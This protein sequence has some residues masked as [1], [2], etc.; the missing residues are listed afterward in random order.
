M[1]DTTSS[2]QAA[3]SLPAKMLGAASAE[4]D[5]D[6]AEVP[7]SDV[8]KAEVTPAHVQ[9]IA[10]ADN[11]VPAVAHGDSERPMDPGLQDLGWS[12]DPKVPIPVLHGMMN[13]DVWTLVRR[14]NKQ[15]YHAKKLEEEPQGGIDMNIADKD[16]FTPDKLRSTLERIYMSVGLGG[17]AFFKH[18]ARVRSWKEYRRTSLFFVFY[19][20]GWV[21]DFLGPIMSAFIILLLASPQSRRILFPPAPLAAISAKTGVARVPKA[22]HLGSESLTGAAES[23]KGEAVENE[24]SNLVG[25]V[26]HMAVSAAIG[27]DQSAAQASQVGDVEGD[28]DDDVDDDDHEADSKKKSE[29][30]KMEDDLPDP[31]AIT[32]GSKAAHSKASDDKIEKKG[33]HSAEPVQSAVWGSAQPI[34][35]TLEDLVDTWE[36]FGNALSPTAPFA[37]HGPRLKIASI[38]APIFLLSLFTTPYMVYKG[39]T[40]GAGFGFF[41]QPLF[42]HLKFS[43]L[44]KFLDEKIPDWPRYLELRNSILKGVPTNAQL[45]IT[46]LRIG[47]ANKCP[48]PPPPPAVS[49][50]DATAKEG[51]EMTEDLPEE[52]VQDLKD[53]VDEKETEAPAEEESKKPKHKKG[54]R[55]LAFIK[56]TAAAGT[57][58]ALGTNRVKAEAG[59]QH[60]RQKVGVVK[61]D[62][63]T[64]AVGDGP[65]SFRGRYKGKRGLIIIS[66]SATTPC[67]SFEKEL[68]AHA[69][70]ALDAAKTFNDSKETDTKASQALKAAAEK[71]RP[72]PLFSIAID[73]IVSCRKL[74]GLGFK[75]KLIVGWALEA[76]VADGIEIVTEDGNTHVITALPRRDEVWNR[77]VSMGQQKWELW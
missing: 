19:L 3:P 42:D 43:D 22:G 45:T 63:G 48:L 51:H 9:D 29:M 8:A 60:A 33:D 61:K 15:T 41:A 72:T 77:L 5:Q 65:A 13:E 7:R 46:L 1:T 75:G 27:N 26:A 34:L 4:A 47:E 30:A 2:S 17:A 52:Y 57:T 62:L 32:L 53:H 39:A 50:P 23:Y 59:F 35:H 55:F 44:R 24:A 54:S 71:A 10:G 38:V 74:G 36:R 31:S 21:F 12:E 18:I 73:E 69:K 28:D 40:F 25:S 70:V 56:G 58:T 20:V 64:E 68:P 66:T 11:A 49:A 37:Q 6:N 16:A 67:V 76:A 14:F